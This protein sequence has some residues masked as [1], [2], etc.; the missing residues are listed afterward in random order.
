MP[1][2]MAKRTSFWLFLIF[3]CVLGV[4]LY[5]AF[6]SPEFSTDDAYQVIRQVEHIRETGLPLFKDPLLFQAQTSLFLPGYY[7]VLAAFSFLFPGTMYLKIVPNLFGALLVFFA[8]L[9]SSAVTKDRTANLLVALVAGFNPLFFRSTFNS[10]SIDNLIA[11]LLFLLV[12]LFIK[13]PSLE[14][15]ANAF[16]LLLVFLLFTTPLVMIFLLGSALFFL[17][18]RLQK[19]RVMKGQVEIVLFSV[20][21]FFWSILIVFKRPFLDLGVSVI[22]QNIPSPLVGVFFSAVPPLQIVSLIGIFPLFAGAYAIYRNLFGKPNRQILLMTAILLGLVLLLFFHLIQDSTGFVYFALFFTLLF[23]EFVALADDWFSRTKFAAGK[24]YFLLAIVVLSIFSSVVPAVVYAESAL[25]DTPTQTELDALSWIEQH[26][27]ADSTILVPLDQA[28]LLQQKTR[29]RVVMN[30]DFLSMKDVDER[31]ADLNTMYTSL[32]K[33]NTLS[34]MT[35]YGVDY[36]LFSPRI[37]RAFNIDSLA[38]IDE[39]CFT[40]TYDDGVEVYRVRCRIGERDD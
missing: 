25:A 20:I 16:L 12:Y 9:L 29:R 34:L 8:Y 18:L 7:Y 10:L 11:P 3:L 38:Y 37:S 2:N 22:W 24:G 6:Q 36:V 23:G 35:T 40:R 13:I 28:S 39:R 32:Y 33:T 21:L 14:Q 4:R 27:A 30:D 26:T 17:L 19:M 15:K 31:Y 1:S 5:F